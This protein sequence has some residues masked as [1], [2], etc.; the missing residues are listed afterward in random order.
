MSSL[1]CQI[2]LHYTD[3]TFFIFQLFVPVFCYSEEE[4]RWSSELEDIKKVKAARQT[5]LFLQV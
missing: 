3:L 1:F 2:E 5:A 4:H